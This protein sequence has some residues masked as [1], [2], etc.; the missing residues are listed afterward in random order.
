MRTTIKGELVTWNATRFR[1]NYMF[2]KNM[3]RWK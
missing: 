1:T 3:L 2:L